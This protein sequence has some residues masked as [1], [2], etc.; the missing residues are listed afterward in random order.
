MFAFTK[1]SLARQ[2][3][4]VSLLILLVGMISVGFFVGYQI[5]SG[6]IEQSAIITAL[7]IDSFVSPVLKEIPLEIAPDGIHPKNTEHL[8]ALGDILSSTPLGEN[9]VTL[10]IWL[11]DGEILYS[12]N[13]NLIG[14]HFPVGG[15]LQRALEGEV[16]AG[17]TDLESPE[18]MYER[19]YWDRL[20]ET[21]AP[22]RI[23]DNGEVFAVAEF[24]QLPDDLLNEIRS[25][26]V[27]SWLMVGIAT[28][29]MYFLLANLVNRASSTIFNQQNELE[30]KVAQ[31]GELLKQNQ[32]L[33][34]RIQHAAAR[35]TAL[36]EQFLRRISTDLHDG[37]A[38]DLALA[39][40]RIDPLAE[41][42]M[43]IPGVG[44]KGKMISDD[45]QTIQNSL[46][47]A[48][49]DIRAISSG[50]RLPE[51]EHM[52]PTEVVKRAVHDYK[53]KT[54]L[55]VST[56]IDLLPESATM[57]VKITLYRVLQESLA[58]GCRHAE[59]ADQ[60]VKVWSV[61]GR[62]QVEISDS[63]PGFDPESVAESDQ[64]GLA[65]MREQVEV[66]GG[67]FSVRSSPGEG[68]LI[69]AMFPSHATEDQ[70]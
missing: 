68:T 22:I 50:L 58:N 16:S 28:V 40:L 26:Q 70:E 61:D 17:I 6:V 49:T 55:E 2:F 65:G 4:V 44:V 3:M 45:F 64:L 35:T 33:H 43:D 32:L 52:K 37:P 27:Q 39:L 1:F 15:K 66:L 18:H 14:Q 47:S 25:A 34:R 20:I 59:G 12:P 60:T 62:I 10:K 24:Y 69:R 21:Y 63:G 23:D 36:N 11:P 53:R 38:Q 51:L 46:E 29:I 19:Q 67:N 8:E 48:I 7:Y 9:V 54:D 41:A 30:E 42:V 13:S 57:P 31:L 5:E 56:E